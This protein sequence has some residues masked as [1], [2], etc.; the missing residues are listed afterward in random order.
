MP[1]INAATGAL[2]IPIWAVGAVAAVFLVLIMMAVAQ[3]GTALVVNTG[4]RALIAIAVITAGWLYID[5]ESRAERTALR[6]GLDERSAALAARAQAP[7][8]VL[9][10]LNGL[11]GESIEL[12]C[13]KAVFASPETVSS[14]LDYVATQLN[15]LHDGVAYSIRYDTDYFARVTSLQNAL[16]A[17]RFGLVAHVFAARGCTV[18]KC[19]SYSI[20]G[21]SAR[22]LDN[23]RDH[24]FD[25]NVAKFAPGWSA[26]HGSAVAAADPPTGKP[27]SSQYDFPSANSIPP[28]NIM[29]PEPAPPAPRSAVTGQAPRQAVVPPKPRP[30]VRPAAPVAV[31]EGHASTSPQ[32]QQ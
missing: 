9:G 12:A 19:E 24:L 13:D 22:M 16:R 6:R 28:V 11:A 26:P 27:V 7:G 30:P 4:F 23:L 18:E 14:A 1:E 2:T 20:L 32:Q 5:H 29:T 8:S 21:D 31:G 17:D 10:C 3:A 25:T 15:L